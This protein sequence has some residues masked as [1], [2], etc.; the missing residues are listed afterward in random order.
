MK[1]ALLGSRGIPAS[2]SGFETFYEQLGA[3][4]AARG[5]QVTVYNRLHHITYQGTIYR[6]VNLVSLPSLPTKH[7]D[8]ISHAFFSLL[9]AL[10]AKY[11]IL[12]FVIVGNSPVC[13]L[14]KKLG[15]IV[16]LNVDGADAER[17]KWQGFAKHYIRFSEHLASRAAD[18]IIADSRVIVERYQKEF[19]CPTVFIPYGAVPWP[20]EK[21]ASNTEVLKRF[22]LES[23]GYILF[24]SRL[25]PE[26]KAHLL[27]EAFRQAHPN[28]KLVIV[29]DAPYSETYKSQLNKLVNRN[30]IM[31]GY[32]FGDSYRQISSHCRFF[33]LPSGIEGTRPVLLDQMGFG[34]CVLVRNNRAN[35]E[36]VGNAGIFFDQQRDKES[37]AEKI[38]ELSTD[39]NQIIYY[40]QKALS[41]VQ[42]VYSWES[43]VDRYEELFLQLTRDAGPFTSKNRIPKIKLNDHEE[44]TRR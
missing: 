11:D 7:L 19:G 23:D 35:Q 22:G 30:V 34:N 18:I 28:L 1:I 38:R 4:L 13:W 9:H 6:G 17:D 43:I 36:V 20:R 39:D 15:K 16:L 42:E 32:L 31:T 3:R 41:R 25:T 10:R 2:Y 40:R 8:T 5:H 24:V 26:N 12:Y 27:I 29:G 44:K 21:E 37:L 14:A 33:V